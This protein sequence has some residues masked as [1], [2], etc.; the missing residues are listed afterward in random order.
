MTPKPPELKNISQCSKI[1]D[2]SPFSSWPQGL[3]AVA[4]N[5]FVLAGFSQSFVFDHQVKIEDSQAIAALFRSLYF[6][7]SAM[8]L[9]KLARRASDRLVSWF[10]VESVFNKFQIRWNDQTEKLVEVMTELPAG[11]QKWTSDKRWSFSDFSP[12]LSASG[13][14]LEPLHLA[15]MEKGVSR[16]LAVQALELSVELLLME[17]PLENLLPELQEEPDQWIKRLR[18]LRYPQTTRTD[19]ESASRIQDLPWP[20]SSKIRWVRQGDKAGIE[21]K[22]FVSNPTDLKKYMQSLA[23]VHEAMEQLPTPQETEDS[24]YEESRLE[25]LVRLDSLEKSGNRH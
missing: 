4:V 12:L 2:F 3:P 13:L 17:H 21:L 22:L 23:R 24:F 6:E 19:S 15:L 8:E 10:P 16:S 1:L 11:F 5:G 20:G 18:T 25:A 9:A 7:L 14:V